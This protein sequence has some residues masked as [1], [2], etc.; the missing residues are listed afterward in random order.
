MLTKRFCESLVSETSVT[1]G[2]QQTTRNVW[3]VE[4]DSSLDYLR[5]IVVLHACLVTINIVNCALHAKQTNTTMVLLLAALVKSTKGQ[6]IK[7]MH[8]SV[9]KIFM[10]PSILRATIS[11]ALNGSSKKNVMQAQNQ[12][13]N[14]TAC[15]ATT[16]A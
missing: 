6:T 16:A 14:Q 5:T 8:A 10:I 9:M 11:N 13:L 7:K 12:A 15:R 3:I 2:L 4:K 1:F